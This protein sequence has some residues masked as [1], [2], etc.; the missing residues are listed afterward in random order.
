VAIEGCVSSHYWGRYADNF[1]HDVRIISPKK[2]KGFLQGHKTDAND[3]LTIA[4]M[5]LQIGLKSS[6]LKVN[7]NKR[8][9]H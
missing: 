9:K 6:S 4:N 1:D 8:F 3:A 7:N 5:S 2:V